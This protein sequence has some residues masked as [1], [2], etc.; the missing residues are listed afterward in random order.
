MICCKVYLTLKELTP[1]VRDLVLSFGERCS[2]LMISKIAAQY[3]PEAVF[4][5]ASEVIKTDNAFG[6]AKVNMELT[7][8][9]IRG[10]YAGE[11][12]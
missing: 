9:L 2:T 3:F 1:K 6:N 10:F 7:E 8:Q 12:R 5:D 4:V 11:Q